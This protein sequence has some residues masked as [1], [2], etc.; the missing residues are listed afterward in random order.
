[1]LT[2][3]KSWLKRNVE[4]I[5]TVVGIALLLPYLP[6]LYLLYKIKSVWKGA[7]AGLGYIVLFNIPVYLKV[8]PIFN[9]ASVWMIIAIITYICYYFYQSRR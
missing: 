9:F 7:M 3:I 1:M 8:H 5:E 6:V 4:N 2:N